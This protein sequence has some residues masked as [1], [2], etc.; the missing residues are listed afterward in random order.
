M[1]VDMKAWLK[2]LGDAHAPLVVCGVLFLDF[3]FA[4]YGA[5]SAMLLVNRM[6]A[7]LITT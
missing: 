2:L 1:N 4:A 7:I 6:T 5:F 3:S